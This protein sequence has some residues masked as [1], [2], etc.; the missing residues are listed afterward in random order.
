[1]RAWGRLL[2]LSLTASALADAAAGL[3]LGAGAWPSGVAPWVLLAAS[4]CVKRR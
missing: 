4:A 3:V 1:M 2:R